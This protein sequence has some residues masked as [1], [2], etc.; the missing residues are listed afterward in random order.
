MGIT[1]YVLK[2]LNN[3]L[4]NG[5]TREREEFTGAYLNG[6]TFGVEYHKAVIVS[7]AK[8]CQTLKETTEER[9]LAIIVNHLVSV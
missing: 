9:N 2:R 3:F 1:G 6:L 7:I 5:K 8:S 4:T